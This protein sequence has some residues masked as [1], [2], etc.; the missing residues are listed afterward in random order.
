MRAIGSEIK[1]FGAELVLIGNG[2]PEQGADFD[3]KDPLPFRLLVDPE[4]VGYKAAELKR[5]L[6]AGFRPRTML[7]FFSALRGG[8]RGH[9]I[10]GNPYQLG[11]VFL[12]L[13]SGNVRYS[14]VSSELGDEPAA[15][16][17]LTSLEVWANGLAT[18]ATT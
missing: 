2:T 7:R 15:A 10:R 16:E 14:R 3:R 5:S 4:L 1:R 8:Y 17:V 6:L 18:S 13:P 12:I 11:G 9:G